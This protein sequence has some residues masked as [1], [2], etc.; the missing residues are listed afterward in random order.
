MGIRLLMGGIVGQAMMLSLKMRSV[1]LTLAQW[2]SSLGLYTCA[3]RPQWEL[4]IHVAVRCDEKQ[5]HPL[6][7]TYRMRSLPSY[8]DLELIFA[9]PVQGEDVKGDETKASQA[10]S[11]DQSESEDGYKDTFQMVVHA[12]VEKDDYLCSSSSGPTWTPVMD[13][14]LIDLMLEQVNRGNKVGETFTEQAWAEMAESF[15]A[16]FGL[17]ADMFTLENRYILM[18]KER[19]DINNILNLD[20]F[21]WDGEKQI[22]VAEDEHWEAYIKEHPDATIYKGKTLDSYVDLCKLY[23]HLSHEGFNCE[24]L[25]IELDNYG[26][27]I[28]IVDDDFSSSTHKQQQQHSKRTNQTPYLG[29]KAQ[30]TGVEMMRKPLCETEG[31][32]YTR[33]H[34]A[35][36]AL[37]ALPE[38]DDELLLDACDLLEDEKK[39]KTF[40]ALDVSLR[41]KWLVRKLRPPSR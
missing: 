8:N 18:M 24:N 30:K 1:E 11:C 41:R 19:D 22:I 14:C 5:E 6:A 13:R 32:D 7:R 37:Q 29:R 26:H 4:D 35:I 28:D 33:M 20:G 2:T 17:Q 21:V 12:G 15:N 36:D 40:L 25:M 23:E 3:H 38:M 16:K 9:N 39:A 34:N 27:E 31:D 10:Q